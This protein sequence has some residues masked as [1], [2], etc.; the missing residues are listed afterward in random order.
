MIDRKLR[1]KGR[2]ENAPN[3][4]TDMKVYENVIIGNFLY[5]LG[6]SIGNLTK[7]DSFVSVVNLLQQTPDDVPLSDLLYSSPGILMIIEFKLTKN[8]DGKKKE[9]EKQQKLEKHLIEVQPELIPVSREVHWYIEA[10]ASSSYLVTEI[11]PYIDA[12]KSKNNPKDMA[13]FLKRTAALAV[14]GGSVSTMEQMNQYIATLAMVH[15]RKGSGSG[16]VRSGGI[17]AKITPD[18]SIAYMQTESIYELVM[19]MGKIREER[20]RGSERGSVLEH[21]MSLEDPIEHAKKKGRSHD[22]DLG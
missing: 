17:F 9:R 13:E 5:G 6:I 3:Q 22:L 10:D 15:R 12:F 14:K 4:E 2:Q 11:T 8:I 18:G 16:G 7:G 20:A 21:V 1:Q 19:K